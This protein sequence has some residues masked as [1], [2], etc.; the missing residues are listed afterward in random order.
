MGQSPPSSTYND[1]GIG[2]P[3]FQ[4]KA[5]FGDIYPIAVKW[6]SE[7]NKVAEAEDVLIS[8]R[9][10]VGPTNLAR[11]KSAFGRGL[12]ALRPE[13]GMPSRF[14][15]YQLR[16]LEEQIA[17]KATGTT[18]AAINK[19]I[20]EEQDIL[21]APLS[22]Q[23]RIVDAIEAR[24]SQ[25]DTWLAVMG[26]LREQLPRL[27]AS[28]LKAAVEG[29]LV[30]QDPNDEPADALL[31]RILDERRQKWEADYLAELTA[32]GKPT[33][34]D[35]KWKEKYPAP[36]E[37]EYDILSEL[38]DNWMWATLDQ[39]SFQVT[40]G[41]RGWAKYYADEGDLFVRVGNF[42]EMDTTLDLSEV[43]FVNPPGGAEGERTRLQLDDLL[44][45]ITAAVGL[46]AV[47]DERVFQWG[48]AY[49]N[50][51]VSLTR[52]LVGTIAHYAALVVASDFGQKQVRDKTYGQVKAG[53]NLD[54]IRSLVIPMPPL[55][56]QQQVVQDIASRFSVIDRL[57]AT[58][59]VNVKRA[60]RMRQSILKQ[61]FEGQLVDQD[62]NDEP[63][64][65]LLE[66]IQAGRQRRAEEEAQI[67]KLP[68]IP[69]MNVQIG[70]KS[71]YET[72]KEA[73][74]PLSARE[75]FQQAGYAHETIDDFY[76][77][78]REA[79]YESRTIRTRPQ[80][81]SDEVFLEVTR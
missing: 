60:E 47:V 70:R 56:Y 19:T 9:A 68:R 79:V 12:A 53:L 2:L 16:Y 35:D 13:L 38:P 48:K 81:N 32:Q 65:K 3:F 80:R 28:I 23:Q 61:A 21:L 46:P 15:L 36:I 1:K 27:R 71:L 75:L 25:L 22:E 67:P 11:E 74:K 69:K 50:Q 76:E 73:G 64:I 26:K 7:P 4:G 37:P 43:V 18:F 34:K 30:E 62:S 77:E 55:S 10:P 40:S 63:A 17:G 41:S 57:E 33:P 24:F 52:L 51:H 66:R 39:L 42:Q 54:D 14:F 45:T 58:V 59:E 49:I 20:L 72:L 78:L 8:V 29:R 31:Q 44:I 6:C 5:E